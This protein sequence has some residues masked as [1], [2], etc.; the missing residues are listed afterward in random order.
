[1]HAVRHETVAD[2]R[3]TVKIRCSPRG[4]ANE[5]EWSTQLG[6]LEKIV[7]VLDD[8]AYKMSSRNVITLARA[9][10]IIAADASKRFN[11]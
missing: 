1:M 3:H 2:E 5:D 4:G 10:G 7:H 9:E 6:S 11:S 8:F